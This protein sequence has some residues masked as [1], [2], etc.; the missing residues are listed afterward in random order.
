MKNHQQ[1]YGATNQHSVRTGVKSPKTRIYLH[2]P[3]IKK[4][5][6]T[7]SFNPCHGLV[8]GFLREDTFRSTSRN[9]V[10]HF[11][12][13]AE[14]CSEVTA[15]PSAVVSQGEGKGN[16]LVQLYHPRAFSAED[17]ASPSSPSY[18][19]GSSSLDKPTEV[20]GPRAGACQ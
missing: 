13:R 12:R 19:L 18:L 17:S 16:R 9:S 5:K 11:H 6:V 2:L 14:G 7:Y 4:K 1:C 8:Q 10:P 20:K 15:M 3:D